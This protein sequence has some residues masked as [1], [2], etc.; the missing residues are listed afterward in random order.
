M[1]VELGMRHL[2]S[3]VR[4]SQQEEGQAMVEYALLVSLVAMAALVGVQLFG[5]GVA[6]LYTHIVAVYPHN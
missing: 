2:K 3:L 6:S 5:H 1:T 4:L